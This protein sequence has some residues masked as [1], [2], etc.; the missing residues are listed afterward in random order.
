M[1]GPLCTFNA[2]RPVEQLIQTY[3][4]Q[5]NQALSDCIKVSESIYVSKCTGLTL[6]E[7][8]EARKEVC[9]RTHTKG[10][11]ECAP[12]LQVARTILNEGFMLL[13]EA[14][15][16]HFHDVKYKSDHARRRLLQMPLACIRIDFK[17]GISECYILEH[18]TQ[19]NYDSI[20]SLLKNVIHKGTS[21][22]SS[23]GKNEIRSLLAL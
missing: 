4:E 10:Q 17:P 18:R 7:Y 22:S 12:M 5:C 19:T 2:G 8:I 13:K 21:T 14:Y 20:A 15:T 9:R 1:S 6:K 23:L 11:C 3:K 16:M